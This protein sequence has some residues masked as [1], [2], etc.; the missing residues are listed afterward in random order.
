V[1]APAAFALVNA[2][3]CS[4]LVT[5]FVAP[6]MGV[7]LAVGAAIGLGP[8]L[9]GALLC[10]V[11]RILG[12]VN[13]TLAGAVRLSCA[14]TGAAPW[15]VLLQLGTS[16]IS[17]GVGLFVGTV[18][19]L[20]GLI[21]YSAFAALTVFETNRDPTVLVFGAL[22][23]ATF[24]W[25]TCAS[26]TSREALYTRAPDVVAP[27]PRPVFV[28]P[29]PRAA[30]PPPQLPE[31]SLRVSSVPPGATVELDGRPVG[32]APLD[33][34]VPAGTPVIQ[35]HLKLGLSEKQVQASHSQEE[36]VV[37]MPTPPALRFDGMYRAIR[38]KRAAWLRFT[39]GGEVSATE[40]SRDLTASRAQHALKKAGRYRLEGIALSFTLRAK[41][42]AKSY[43]GTVGV[44]TLTLKGDDE[45][46]PVEYV[47]VTP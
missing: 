16:R 28:A 32:T 19:P 21:A 42:G 46:A 8:W 14:L 6:G 25:G 47:L 27:A 44:D 3:V 11:L 33:V 39:N 34:V 5:A 23:I 40:L 4:G 20:I 1:L 35:L 22:S 2:L 13:A 30:V 38:G 37:V 41:H 43:A 7:A 36:L 9:Y 15:V 18:L 12:S 26:E 10:A 17:P 31:W 24:C 45:A 29:P